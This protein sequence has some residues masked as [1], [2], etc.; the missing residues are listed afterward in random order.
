MVQLRQVVLQL[1]PNF[2]SNTSWRFVDRDYEFTTANALTENFG[3]VYDIT[4]L[5]ADMSADFI[6]VKIGD[7][8]GNAIPNSLVGAESRN[9]AGTLVFNMDD[10]FVQVGEKVSVEFLSLIHI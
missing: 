9:A 1:V 5:S 7:L 2:P 10:Q 8:N 6:A 3:E 4:N